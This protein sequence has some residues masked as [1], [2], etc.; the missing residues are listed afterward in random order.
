MP[1]LS[2]EDKTRTTDH[3]EIG[4][5]QKDIA[6]RF[7]TLAGTVSEIIRRYMNEGTVERKQG[8]GKLHISTNR[9]RRLLQKILK[10]NRGITRAEIQKKLLTK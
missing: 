1:Q 9:T 5:S 10:S 7:N 2:K 3:F 6:L 8:T 4:Q